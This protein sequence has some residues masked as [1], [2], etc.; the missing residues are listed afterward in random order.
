MIRPQPPRLATLLLQR[1]GSSNTALAGDLAERYH[2][3]QSNAEYWRQVVAAIGLRCWSDVRTHKLV[4]LRAI[5]L[6]WVI[7]FVCFE[8][9]ATPLLRI[10]EVLFT[11][12]L[13][14]WFYLNNIGFPDVF[15]EWW[16]QGPL[17]NGL[18]GWI[19]G[20][21]YRGY[22]AS[23]VLA[24][25]VSLMLVWMPWFGVAAMR[26]DAGVSALLANQGFVLV[27]GAL[28]A[29]V[30]GLTAVTL[31]HGQKIQPALD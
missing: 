22:S 17:F 30:G 27:A 3:R 6:G 31:Q 21:V 29:L 1:L 12:G 13:V 18:T 4:T 2:E 10:D 16:I 9:V 19:V 5:I 24:H 15:R 14:K 8:Y 28:P 23:M 25:V 7:G 20:R 11:R 26:D